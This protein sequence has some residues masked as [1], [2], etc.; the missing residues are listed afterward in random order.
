MDGLWPFDNFW[1]HFAIFAVAIIAF[2]LL[3][4][5]VFIWFERRAFGPFQ[6]RWGPNRASPWGALQPVADAIKVLLKEDIVPAVADKWVHFIAPII[7]FLPVLLIFAVVPFHNGEGLIPQMNIG[8]LYVVAISALSVVG[9]FMAGWGSGNKYSLLGGMR[10]IAQMVS[11]EVPLVLSIISVVL[12]AGS[13][14]MN[15]IVA[16]QEI[17]FFVL[18][19]L[20]FL[21]F[22]IAAMAEI[23]RGPFDLLEADSEI[24]AGFHIEY[25]GMKFAMFYLAEYGHA[26]A[27]SAIAATLFFGGWK[28][29]GDEWVGILWFLVKVMFVFSL[30]IWARVT[31]P[32]LRVDHLMGFGWKFL[33]PLALINLFIV[34]GEVIAWGEIPWWAIF[35]NLPATVILIYVWSRLF[36]FGGGRVEVNA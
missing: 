2:V 14:S 18:M 13:L 30:L 11:Y 29:F 23:N 3:M 27:M 4:V 20:G 5:M 35:I 22:I 33:F 19:P 26:L 10:V 6:M 34:A 21:I 16:A 36:K 28:G 25:S 24:V 31:F 1:A 17:P 9:V 8:I 15:D 7:G 12:V 32:R